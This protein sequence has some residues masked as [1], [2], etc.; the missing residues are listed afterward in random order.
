[1]KTF[2][3]KYLVLLNADCI[4][5]GAMKSRMKGGY[6]LRVRKIL[7]SNL[8]VAMSLRVSTIG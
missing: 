5:H 3:Y 2:F 6:T 4:M 1:M 7:N 8:I